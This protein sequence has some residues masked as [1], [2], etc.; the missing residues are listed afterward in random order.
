MIYLE[1]KSHQEL[2]EVQEE[3][4]VER[5]V[6]V[7]E[8]DFNGDESMSSTDSKSNS[9]SNNVSFSLLLLKLCWSGTSIVISVY[10]SKIIV[11]FILDSVFLSLY[12]LIK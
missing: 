4:V 12:D 7:P 9:T 10:S 1:E 2:K 5:I 3:M 6:V 8:L 11:N